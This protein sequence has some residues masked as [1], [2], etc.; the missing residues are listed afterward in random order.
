MACL[1]MILLSSSLAAQDKKK[2]VEE[3]EGEPAKPKVQVPNL[4]PVKLQ[5]L[6]WGPFVLADEAKAA[7]L[8]EVKKYLDDLTLTADEVVSTA[9]KTYRTAPIARKYDPKEGKPLTFTTLEGAKL[10]LQTE[11]IRQVLHYE[12]RVLDL[13]RQFLD[14][15]FDTAK[16]GLSRFMQLRA[17]E[18][19]ISEG[20]RY[21]QTLLAQG[22]RD[23]AS[24]SKME[25]DL[26]NKLFAIR[27]DELRALTAERDY[28]TAEELAKKMFQ[29]SPGDKVLLEVIEELYVKQTDDQFGARNYLQARLIL[30]A[31]K[32]KYL[33][34]LTSPSTKREVDRLQDVSR[35]LFEE[36]KAALEAKDRTKA[37]SALEAAEQ[38]WP[39][40][41][42]LREFRVKQLGEY[43]VLKVGVRALPTSFSPLSAMTDSD[44]LACQLIYE[45]IVTQRKAP[46]ATAGYVAQL[47]EAPRRI[48]KGYEFT[49]PP[50]L[51][52]SDGTP[53]KSDD[54]QRSFELVSK[55]GTRQFDPTLDN[56]GLLVI[57]QI[58]ETRFSITTRAPALDPI[59][60]MNFPL[61]PA[62]RLPRDQSN[63]A[64]AMA[65]ARQP[66]GT[67]PYVY[68]QSSATEVVFKANPHY[69]RPHLPNGPAI[70]EIHFILYSDWG[71]AR[72]AILDGRWQMLLDGTSKEMD[73]LAGNAQ[74]IVRTPTESVAAEGSATPQFTNPRIYLLGFNYRKPHLQRKEAREGISL[75]INR[76][77]IIENVFRGKTKTHHA[78]LNGPYPLNS[79]GYDTASFSQSPYASVQASAKLRAAGSMPELKL[80]VLAEDIHGIEACKLIQ[81]DLKK[82]GINCSIK[83]TGAAELA[84]EMN[85]P[86][87]E[88]DLLYTTWDYNSETLNLRPFVDVVCT[89]GNGPN[90]MGYQLPPNPQDPALMRYL[91]NSLNNRELE[92]ARRQMYSIHKHVMENAVF[93]PLYQLDKHVAVHRNLDKAERLHP[94]FVFD[95]VEKW[96]LKAGGQ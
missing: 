77:A 17:A 25:T 45:P 67:G 88:F 6:G 46:A 23:K 72:Q 82:V 68:T 8:P 47:T 80:A 64:A 60:F 92:N 40:L 61:L 55:P 86:V 42:G 49:I 89:N 1:M 5:P 74:V 39:T 65:L 43:S 70:Q 79:W 30:E 93:V 16:P 11:Q 41:P 69:K 66:L 58:D 14:R 90:F 12:E 84:V 81:A 95:S 22:S 50:T 53:V 18:M 71:V 28:A 56:D 9:N 76:E 27:I 63:S 24:W 75:A 20:L 32:E 35:R 7:T 78:V 38:A 34:P 57:N 4:E 62:S 26:K 15:R 91:S 87:P 54:V 13:T 94:V 59:T 83:P 44:K 10:V 73:E 36:V 51:K 48:A 3:E 85:K 31:L 33:N 96:V 19:V 2:A 29:A 21:H 52:W 37:L